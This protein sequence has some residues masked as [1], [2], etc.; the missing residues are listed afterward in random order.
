MKF[1][2]T[3]VELWNEA[4]SPVNDVDIPLATGPI[5]SQQ[6]DLKKEMVP[7]T[8]EGEIDWKKIKFNYG[9]PGGFF[10]APGD[11]YYE[12]GTYRIH[13]TAFPILLASVVRQQDIKILD[14]FTLVSSATKHLKGTP[15]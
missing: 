2:R 6:G 3:C 12:V 11:P 13:P 8:P 10:F 9:A 14:K 5:I 7:L 1:F 4:N 15:I